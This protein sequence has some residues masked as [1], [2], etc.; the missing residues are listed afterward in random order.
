MKCV[1]LTIVEALSTGVGST[2]QACPIET[3]RGERNGGLA[4]QLAYDDGRDDDGTGFLQIS[5][6]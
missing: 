1:M 6:P 4:Y 3:N 5:T 2:H